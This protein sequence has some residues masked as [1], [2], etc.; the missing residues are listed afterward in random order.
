MGV[1]LAGESLKHMK[2]WRS[3]AKIGLLVLGFTTAFSMVAVGYVLL[4]LAPNDDV[5]DAVIPI[6]IFV[7]AL[8]AISPAVLLLRERPLEGL[9]KW[10]PPTGTGSAP[11]QLN[12]PHRV[13]RPA[14]RSLQRR[15]RASR[16]ER[17]R[18]IG[19]R[20]NVRARAR[21]ARTASSADLLSLEDDSATRELRGSRSLDSADPRC[22]CRR[23]E[24]ASV[25]R[26]VRENAGRLST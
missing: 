12:R 1:K 23:S 20:A 14:R 19:T 16:H 7:L 3:I 10:S 6:I 4:Y 24:W 5:S 26:A 15:R 13:Q 21:E 18:C 17:Q 8:F 11:V 2:K 22:G 25:Q 9:D